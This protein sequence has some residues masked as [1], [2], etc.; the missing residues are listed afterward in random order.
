MD[1]CW[2]GARPLA[3]LNRLRLTPRLAMATTIV[4]PSRNALARLRRNTL[5]ELAGGVAVVGIV[6][7]LGFAMPAMH[8]PDRE[9]PHLMTPEGH[10]R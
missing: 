2:I 1:A 3:A 5:L 7:A 4:T 10:I 8:M 9:H 6:A